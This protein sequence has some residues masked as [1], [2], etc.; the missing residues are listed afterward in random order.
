[1]TSPGFTSNPHLIL[2]LAT[3]SL[4]GQRGFGKGILFPWH[5][6]F[7]PNIPLPFND[8]LMA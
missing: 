3:V 7:L 6:G 1:M 2:G 5:S 8:G 4:P